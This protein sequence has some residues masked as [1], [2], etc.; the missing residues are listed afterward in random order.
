M[1]RLALYFLG[2]PRLELDGEVISLSHHKA[3]ALLAY[4]GVTRQ[5]HTRQALAALLWPDYN[6]ARALGEVRRMIWVINKN[7]GQ[8]WLKV[9]RQT[10][11]LP[12]QPGLWLDIERFRELLAAAQPHD[13]PSGQVGPACLNPLT[14]A[15]A[16]ARGDFLAGF[17]VP[18]NPEFDTWQTFEAESLRRELTGALKRLV[19]LLIQSGERSSEQTINYARRWLALDPLHEPAHRQ[20]MQLYAWAGQPAA[21][22]QQY[23]SCRRLLE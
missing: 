22:L 18:N 16:L 6:S 5:Q 4:L 17:T 2:A 23:Q 8:G 11:T 20:L 10:V 21:A 19:Q 14:E 13:H 9:D 15:V 12:P 3:V 7:L 1:S